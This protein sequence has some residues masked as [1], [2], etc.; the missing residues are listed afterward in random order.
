MTNK[1]NYAS[2]GTAGNPE[3]FYDEGYK[4]SVDMPSWLAEKGLDAY[5]YAA[6]R[7]VRIKE[8]T[9]R[10]IAEQAN[11]MHIK[12]SLHAPY[13][14]NFAA[15]E[16]E[17]M[18]KNDEYIIS[19]LHAAHNLGAD[20]VVF[21]SGGQGKASRSKAMEQT[22]RGIAQML[23]KTSGLGFA[24]IML[25]P[26]TMGKKGQIGTLEEVVDI[27][28]IDRGRLIPTVD[29]GHLHAVTGGL[30]VDKDDYKRAFDFIGDKL[31]DNALNNLHVHFSRIEFT[32]AGEKKHWTF[33]DDYGP[34]FE[35]FMDTVIDYGI[36][37]RI[38]CE[39]AGTQD[40]DALQMKN[41]YLNNMQRKK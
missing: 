21:H 26:E 14:I 15:T 4:A 34:P 3:A 18:S 31:G 8:E 28:L 37:P 27:C 17:Q 36:A 23:D 33:A 25:M 5:E 16:K 11:K 1:N 20:R 24:N 35:P 29:F 6:G 41:Y 13:F 10:A 12:M 39:S 2:F 30:Y 32:K 40:I 19:S 7:G 9:A 22:K 38:I